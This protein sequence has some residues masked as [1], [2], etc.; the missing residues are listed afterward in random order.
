M[1]PLKGRLKGETGEK[2]HMVPLID[3]MN[4]GISVKRWVRRWLEVIVEE[5]E[6]LQGWVF[7]RDNGETMGIQDL[8]K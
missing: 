1:V 4:F 5:D 6:R 8:D 3:E 7:Q 2:W